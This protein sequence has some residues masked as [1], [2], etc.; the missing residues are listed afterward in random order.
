MITEIRTY[1][2]AAIKRCF[3]EY[4]DKKDPFGNDD[5]ATTETDRIYRVII[6]E[7]TVTDGG[8]TDNNEVPVTVDIFKKGYSKPQEAFDEIYDTAFLLKNEIVNPRAYQGTF[9]Y[10]AN[11]AITPSPF[12]SNDN[13]IQLRLQFLITTVTEK[14]TKEI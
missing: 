13:V 10:V 6:G 9:A 2:N 3:P 4:T 7:N 11:Q 5:I 1:F 14:T 12:E 8:V